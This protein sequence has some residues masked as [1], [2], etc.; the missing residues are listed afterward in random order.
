MSSTA[1]MP[2]QRG[3]MPPVIEKLRASLVVR[4]CFSTRTRPDPL[5]DA[6][7]KE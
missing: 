3:H 1:P 4:P 7:L 5:I 2:S 6:T